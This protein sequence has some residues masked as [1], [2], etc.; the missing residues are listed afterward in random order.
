MSKSNNLTDFLTDVAD[1]IRTK[2][3]ASGTINPQNFSNEIINLQ[4]NGA[5]IKG[6]HPAY[7]IFSPDCWEDS[8]DAINSVKVNNIW[9]DGK[10]IYWS[11]GYTQK[12]LDKKKQYLG[13]KRMDI[14]V[15]C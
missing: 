3:E 12:V 14:W 13:C 15:G 9:T 2:K 10:D 1:A 6:R 5:D 8:Q 4:V 11:D 7:D